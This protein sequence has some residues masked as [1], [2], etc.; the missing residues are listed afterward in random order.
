MEKLFKVAAD[1][2]A[3]YDI[4]KALYFWL[5]DWIPRKGLFD[6]NYSAGCRDLIVDQYRNYYETYKNNKWLLAESSFK[7]NPFYQTIMALSIA[8]M[9]KKDFSER[10]SH[11]T[12]ILNMLE[13]KARWKRTSITKFDKIVQYKLPGRPKKKVIRPLKSVENIVLIKSSK[14]WNNNPIIFY[15]YLSVFKLL[16]DEKNYKEFSA[17]KSFEDLFDSAEE[18][19]GPRF[20][21]YKTASKWPSVIMQRRKIFQGF[22]L[23]T[24]YKPIHKDDSTYGVG[25]DCFMKG[26]KLLRNFKN[27][28]NKTLLVS[29]KEFLGGN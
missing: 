7:Q 28:Q 16:F 10:I 4:Y 17:A 1:A 3:Q 19:Y 9:S 20:D 6:T 11:I 22:D 12:R 26:H 23:H 21:Q 29:A 2:Y 27:R 24:L 14:C 18:F 25:I 8:G 15:I 5:G 13:K